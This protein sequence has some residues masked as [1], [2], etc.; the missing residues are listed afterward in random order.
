MKDGCPLC[1]WLEDACAEHLYFIKRNK[2]N[3]KAPQRI[4]CKRFSTKSRILRY[5]C[6]WWGLIPLVQ[7]SPGRVGRYARRMRRECRLSLPGILFQGDQ[8]A[9]RSANMISSWLSTMSQF[10]HRACQCLTIRWEARYS[11]RRR[12]SSL[13]NEGLFFVI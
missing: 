7:V 2:P 3:S 10:W 12:E 9:L 4:L 5:Q 8:P 1:Y 11:I 13:V 6:A